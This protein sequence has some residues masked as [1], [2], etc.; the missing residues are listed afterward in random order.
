[1]PAVG[2]DLGQQT[3]RTC[4][5]CQP[6]CDECEP[7]P[8]GGGSIYTLCS[9]STFL[10][11]N[12]H[13]VSTCPVRSFS[14]E[15]QYVSGRTCEECGDN[16]GKCTSPDTCTRC[17]ASKHLKPDGVCGEPCPTGYTMAEDIFWNMLDG[18]QAI[19]K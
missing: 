19:K 3:G 12:G 2:A 18:S 5:A 14:Q 6:D 1:M 4:E 15:F 9:S 17:V 10:T 11:S 13:C 16:C 8:D 7:K